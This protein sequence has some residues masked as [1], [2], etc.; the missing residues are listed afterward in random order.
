TTQ[1]FY[2]MQTPW[3]E[4]L[5][6]LNVTFDL[7]IFLGECLIARNTR[8]HWKFRHG[9]SEDGKSANSGYVIEGFVKKDGGWI[10]PPQRLYSSCTN[11]LNEAYHLATGRT[12]R[13]VTPTML[14]GIVR[15]FSKR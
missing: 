2:Q 8:L 5:R 13:I 4:A 9:L 3:I 11:D 15:D 6:G 7:G 12:W 14:E 1:A 10:D